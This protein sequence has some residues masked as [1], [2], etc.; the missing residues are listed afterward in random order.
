MD[1]AG[2]AS[3]PF[4]QDFARKTG[5]GDQIKPGQFTKI[6]VK[7]FGENAIEF[8]DIFNERGDGEIDLSY[9]IKN[10]SLEFANS[11]A[12]QFDR[13]KFFSAYSWLVKKKIEAKKILEIGCDNGWFTCLL[14]TLY[15]EARVVGIDISPK[16]IELAKER[17]SNLKIN[18]IEFKTLDIIAS[19]NEFV[20]DKFDLVIGITV[21]H[22]IFGS[23][24][25]P[26]GLYGDDSIW[27]KIHVYSNES[28]DLKIKKNFVDLPQFLPIAKMLDPGGKFISFDRWSNQFGLLNWVRLCE[29]CGLNL[30][31]FNS[32]M[33]GVKDCVEEFSESLPVTAFSI[34][35]N[36]DRIK[37]SD[38]ISSIVSFLKA[39]QIQIPENE[40]SELVYNS[41]R[42]KDVLFG[43]EGEYL[44][45]SGS[46]KFEIGTSQGLAYFYRTTILG[47]RK[48]DLVLVCL[49]PDLLQSASKEFFSSI[50]SL[51]VVQLEQFNRPGIAQMGDIEWDKIPLANLTCTL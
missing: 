41:L 36:N 27:N 10:S 17:A 34:R 21:F 23:H 37:T 32:G 49:L 8:L 14:A 11:I 7:K 9:E 1:F 40:F 28:Y 31:L 15:P 45:G 39:K 25:G 3:V 35:K 46:I 44:D 5:I 48:L 12:G 16:A 26:G 42:E 30:D 29:H 20:D 13:P 33:I 18:N 24:G 2:K 6:F 51:K 50:N 22:E 38:E 43:V 47:Y 4:F 19:D